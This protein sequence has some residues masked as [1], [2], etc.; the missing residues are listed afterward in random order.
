MR[1]INRRIGPGGDPAIRISGGS[2]FD[3]LRMSKFLGCHW[4]YRWK[5]GKDTRNRHCPKNRT[6]TCR[7][8]CRAVT[9]NLH[10]EW[11]VLQFRILEKVRQTGN[12]ET[13]HVLLPLIPAV[14]L[15]SGFADSLDCKSLLA[16]F[17]R[18]SAAFQCIF[19][20]ELSETWPKD[21]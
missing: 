14:C 12:S 6:Q 5:W 18:L 11:W 13:R 8:R 10:R 4:I 19:P 9:K 16:W 2:T 15:R 7:T 20:R 17:F 1:G 3:R 21:I